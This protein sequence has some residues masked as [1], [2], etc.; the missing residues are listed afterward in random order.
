MRCVLDKQHLCYECDAD[1][2]VALRW[3]THT[4]IDDIGTM[5]TILN[6]TFLVTLTFHV[7]VGTILGTH[8]LFSVWFVACKYMKKQQQHMCAKMT[9]HALK[10]LC[11]SKP[12]HLNCQSCVNCWPLPAKRL[13]PQPPSP[14][15]GF[16]LYLATNPFT[17]VPPSLQWVAPSQLGSLH[18]YSGSLHL[19]LENPPFLLSHLHH[20][21]AS[22]GACPIPSPRPPRPYPPLPPRPR[23]YPPRPYPPRPYRPL[24]RPLPPRP[25]P[26]H[27]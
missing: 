9:I 5:Q 11:C 19:Y 27:P 20:A 16:H 12:P 6:D 10:L 22:T 21:A 23:P 17:W 15:L 1:A 18:L 2:V 26:L 25:R 7:H 13:F 4:R 8:L 24:P 14:L 3:R